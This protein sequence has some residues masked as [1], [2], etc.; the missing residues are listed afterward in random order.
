MPFA[1]ILKDH[2]LESI[3]PYAF[4]CSSIAAFISPMIGGALADR[5]FSAEQILRWLSIG[6]GLC[7]WTTFYA[8]G[9]HFAGWQ[10]LALLQ[11][12]QLFYS[13]TWGIANAIVLGNL[14]APERQFGNV[15]VWAT[16]GWLIAGPLI[17][18]ALHAD[19]SPAAGYFAGALSFTVAAFTCFL[20]GTPPPAR[21]ASWRWRDILGWDAL[22][23][24]RNPNHRPVFLA[25]GLF[26]IPLS[27]FYPF[28]IM[29]LKATGDPHPAATMSIGQISEAFAMWSLA[30]LLSRYRIK[31]I[32]LLGMLFGLFRYLSFAVNTHFFVVAGV[33]LHGL[34]YTL[35][36]IPI[37]I[38]LERRVEPAF[39]ARAQTLL[40]LMMSGFGALS[41]FLLCGWWHDWC[42]GP[43]GSRW[44][45]YWSVLCLP[46]VLIM[47]FFAISY[48]GAGKLHHPA[49]G[50]EVSP[51]S[52]PLPAG[53]E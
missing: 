3:I 25:A 31:P 13:P 52:T 27:A 6:T 41:G 46:I 20:P 18:F 7:L 1:N 35:V 14:E 33:A 5:H 10:V 22:T 40:T 51:P 32:I 44:T 21:R 38:Y 19:A 43:D 2:G 11:I 49:L 24:L 4:S 53:L 34:C 30:P 36:F 9:H 16:F 28:A 50:L 15:R 47:A 42:A 29:H 37:Q 26:S 45:L 12:Q 39:R 17:S 8:I 23:L 48:R